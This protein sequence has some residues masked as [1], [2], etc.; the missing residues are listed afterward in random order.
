MLLL[1]LSS[2]S[3]LAR[4]LILDPDWLA[5]L[6]PLHGSRLL[7]LLVHLL[8]HAVV[9]GV[10][11]VLFSLWLLRDWL[12]GV[13]EVGLRSGLLLEGHQVADHRARGRA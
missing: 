13:D 11:E 5:F 1:E 3:T 7:S 12:L 4:I 2:A 8:V 10:V 6:W 9:I